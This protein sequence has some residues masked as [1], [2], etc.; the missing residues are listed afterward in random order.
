MLTSGLPDNINQI[1]TVH[2][3]L[4]VHLPTIKYGDI[5]YLTYTPSHQG[6]TSVVLP[7]DNAKNFLWITQNLNKSS[8]GTLEI[9][10]AK[11]LGHVTR[12]TWI[13]D[14]NN[15]KFNYC[16]LVKTC[17]YFD[18]NQDILIEKYIGDTT[19]VI[20]S[21]DPNYANYVSP[22]SQY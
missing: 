1:L 15:N 2:H 5:E 9:N 10:K 22:K 20:Y 19:K 6:Y 7:N 8:Y 21:S 18:S 12:I 13:V 4:W 16:G 17:S 11:T 14:N 3:A